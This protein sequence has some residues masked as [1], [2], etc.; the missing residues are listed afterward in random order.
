MDTNFRM[1]NI[2]VIGDSWSIDILD[3]SSVHHWINSYTGHES[4]NNRLRSLGHTV[5]GNAQG[6]ASIGEQ[7]TVLENLLNHYKDH[8]LMQI[9]GIL[10][11][12]TEWCRELYKGDATGKWTVTPNYNPTDISSSLVIAQEQVSLQLNRLNNRTKNFNIKWMHWGGLSSPWINLPEDHHLLYNDYCYS[13]FRCP[14]RKELC[15]SFT[16]AFGGRHRQTARHLLK[17]FP[18]SDKK[19][20]KKYTRDI[21]AV[22]DWIARNN[23]FF[24]DG[25]HL[26]FCHY[27]PLA[28]RV[29]QY[30]R[31]IK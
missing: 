26:G 12:W 24:P 18:N 13:E 4:I 7:L 5:L 2:I 31:S 3:P 10:V 21:T 30:I 16:Y 20:I 23:N 14:P 9:D 8:E 11:G 28:D 19:I 6:G 27:G 29:D 1:A 17:R 22:Q 25:G 15:L